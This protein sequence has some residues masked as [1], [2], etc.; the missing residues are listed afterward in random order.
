MRK[1]ARLLILPALA[2]TVAAVDP[3]IDKNYDLASLDV[4]RKTIVQIKDNYVD[5]S[6]INP[7]EMFTSSLESVERQVA[8][9]M[10]EVGGPPCD[11]KPANK[12][13]GT[14]ALVGPTNGAP[15][16][17]ILE[18]NRA[19]AAGCGHA[20]SNIPEGHVRVTVGNATREFDYRDIDSIWQIPLKMHEVFGFMKENL[21]TQSDQ[22]EIEY[23]AING[24]LSTLDPHSWLLK[25]DVYKEM[26]VQTR[27]EFGGLG[28]VISM[29]DDRLTVR[30]V[31]RNTPAFKA[32]ADRQRFDGFHG[33]AGSRRSDARQAGHQGLDLRGAQGRRSKE[34]RP[35]ARAGD[36]RDGH[37]QAAR[38]RRRLR[39]ALGILGDDDA[40]HDGRDPRHEAAERRRSEGPGDGSARQSGRLAGAGH[41]GER[42]LRGRGNHRHHRRRQRDAARAQAGAQRRRRARI[43]HGGADLL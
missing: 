26:K 23:A 34:A 27:G 1:T 43:P 40:R 36:V 41:P 17:G 42:R 37:F 3:K 12:E 31:L 13:P 16:G 29:I 30:K 20:N 7:K 21:V 39:A 8:E 35:D 24:M 25:P 33:A 19:Q 9:V 28:F 4:F 14:T 11:D 32:G 5:P 6:R 15:Q 10:V 22:R 38:Q 2:L 18:T